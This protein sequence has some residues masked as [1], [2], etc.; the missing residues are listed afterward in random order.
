MNSLVIT[1]DMLQWL[2]GPFLNTEISATA[3]QRV[4][5]DLR[6]RAGKRNHYRPDTWVRVAE[7]L[8]IAT[9]HYYKPGESAGRL[10]YSAKYDSWLIMWNVARSLIAQAAALVHELAEYYWLKARGE[11]LCGHP[12]VY[13]YEGLIEAE[14]HKLACDVERL[15]VPRMQYQ[16]PPEGLFDI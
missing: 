8:G 11:W 12:V 4:A 13:Y 10:I 9:Q 6:K 1:S 5:E 7:K 14:H 3:V 15:I 16:A 2:P